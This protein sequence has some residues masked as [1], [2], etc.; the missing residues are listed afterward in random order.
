MRFYAVSEMPQDRVE[1]SIDCFFICYIRMPISFALVEHAKLYLDELI[2]WP[3]RLSN[4]HWSA[5][6]CE[7]GS[8]LKIAICSFPA[9]RSA[10]GTA[11]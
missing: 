6:G 10:S 7:L 3:S 5:V 8:A 4:C 2:K 9:L 1:V 11:W